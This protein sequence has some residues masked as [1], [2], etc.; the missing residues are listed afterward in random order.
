[1]MMDNI[2]GNAI[3]AKSKDMH[4]IFDDSDPSEFR[5]IFR[6]NGNGIDDALD[7]DSL[8]EFGVTTTNG[9]GLGLYYARKQMKNLDGT[10]GLYRNDD[11]G[12]SVVLC[13]KK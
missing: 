10:I 13:W 2:I 5:I 3:K 6:D 8:F 12:A 1:M 4:I 9:S 11:C 7:I